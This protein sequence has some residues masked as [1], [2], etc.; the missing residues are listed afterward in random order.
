M[1]KMTA[2]DWRAKGFEAAQYF[3]PAA[4]IDEKDLFAGRSAQIDKMLEAVTEKGKHAVLFGSAALA[5]PLLEKCS[6]R[7]SQKHCG[8]FWPFVSKPIHRMIFRQY[9]EKSSK[10]SAFVQ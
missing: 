9:G 1:A 10:T 2:E 6:L 5:R 7:C 8:T 3:T 4:P